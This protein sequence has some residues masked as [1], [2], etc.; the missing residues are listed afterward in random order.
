LLRGDLNGAAD[1]YGELARH[2]EKP[3]LVEQQLLILAALPQRWPEAETLGVCC[4]CTLARS[5]TPRALALDTRAG[6]TPRSP[7]PRPPGPDLAR[8]AR[9]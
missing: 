7:R 9:R 8:A 2:S 1:A 6:P 4:R 3:D 5:F